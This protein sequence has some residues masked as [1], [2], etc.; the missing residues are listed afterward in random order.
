LEAQGD[1]A[2]AL[3]EY[4]ASLA[5]R[6]P[7]AGADPTNAVWQRDLWVTCWRIAN[8]LERS[9]DPTAAASWQ[10]AYD[11]LSGMKSTGIYIS[12]ADEQFYEQLRQKLGR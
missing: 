4:R 12:A 8:A 5:I 10:R 1:L 3:T 11:V 6:E 2:G 9:G 7:L